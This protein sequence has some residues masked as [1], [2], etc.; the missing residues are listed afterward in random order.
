MAT[1]SAENATEAF[2]NTLKMG[3]KAKEPDVAEFISAMAAGNNAQ[4][5]VVA[6]ERCT[7]HK[8]I[9]ALAAAAVQTGGRVVCIVPRQEDLHVSQTILS[10]DG[11]EFVVGEAENLIKIHYTDADFVVIDCNLEGHVGIL[12][13]VRSRSRRRPKPQSQIGGGGGGTVVVGFNALS[14]NNNDNKGCGGWS[15]GTHILPIGEGVV[16]TRVA[17]ESWKNGGGI[18]GGSGSGR[19]RRSQ[20]VVKVDKWTGEEHVFRVTVPQVRKLIVHA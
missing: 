18:V 1:W 9:L 3:Q 16:V 13:A 17:A 12:G 8:I 5:M 19:R 2:L 10:H 6:Y 11:I 4:L 15:G 14:N 7:D 20:W